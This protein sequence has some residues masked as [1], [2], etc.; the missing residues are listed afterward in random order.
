MPNKEQTKQRKTNY[1]IEAKNT[2]RN[3]ITDAFDYDGA[4]RLEWELFNCLNK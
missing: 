1:Y 2:H 3:R 4:E